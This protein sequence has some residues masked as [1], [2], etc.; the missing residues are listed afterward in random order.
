M[1]GG[2]RAKAGGRAWR[3]RGPPA[4]AVP[5]AVHAA[6]GPTKSFDPVPAAPRPTLA[7]LLPLFRTKQTP[8]P[9]RARAA[10]P[11]HAALGTTFRPGAAAA[12]PPGRARAHP[13]RPRPP[14]GAGTFVCV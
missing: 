11:T 1:T 14:L 9:A 10:Q 7:C 4:A 6:L 13:S 3:A 2:R 8:A 5:V 12:L